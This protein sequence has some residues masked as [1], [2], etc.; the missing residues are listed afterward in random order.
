MPC[1]V[2]RALLQAEACSLNLSTLFAGKGTDPLGWGLLAAP[3]GQRNSSLMAREDCM[4]NS[5]AQKHYQPAWQWINVNSRLSLSMTKMSSRMLL[6]KCVPACIYHSISHN[7]PT[8]VLTCIHNCPQSAQ[9]AYDALHFLDH[10]YPALQ[11][12]CSSANTKQQASKQA[13]RNCTLHC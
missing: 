9:T 7:V 3:G 10:P 12:R 11:H 6:L 5:S 4:I 2:Q 8:P 13:I 1:T